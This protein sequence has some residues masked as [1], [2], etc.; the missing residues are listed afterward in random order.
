MD[1]YN[2]SPFSTVM[3]VVSACFTRIHEAFEGSS[4]ALGH[5]TLDLD[6][7]DLVLNVF[8]GGDMRA[9]PGD[10]RCAVEIPGSGTE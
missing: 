3:H 8:H 6:P 10:A 4:K 7:D 9:S 1:F 2:V 5:L